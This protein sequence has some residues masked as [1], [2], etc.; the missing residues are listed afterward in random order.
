MITKEEII[1]IGS[2]VKPHGIN[3]EISAIYD[4]DI[5]FAKLRC[6]V[7]DIEGIFVPF[8]IEKL[9][10]KSKES[11]LLTLDGINNEVEAKSLCGKSIYALRNDKEM[12]HAL[13]DNDDN[14]LYASDLIG[15]TIVHANGYPIGKVTDIED[16]TENAL[17]IVESTNGKSTYIPIANDLIDD[18]RQEEHIIIMTLPEGILE[19]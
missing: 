4:Y 10:P 6:I 13:S 5:D 1:E 16:S 8:F 7:L 14:G 3:G 15:Y 12:Q 18:I 2:L 17:F 9:R 11:I 19:L